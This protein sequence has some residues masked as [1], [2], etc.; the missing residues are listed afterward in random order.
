MSLSIIIP[1]HNTEQYLAECLDTVLSEINID[2]EIILVE[3]GSIDHSWE[4]CQKY[5]EKYNSVKTVRMET[6]GVSRARNYGIRLAKGD[7]ITFLDSDDCLDPSIIHMAEKLKNN[8]DMDVVLFNYCYLGSVCHEAT[9]DSEVLKH[10]DSDLLRRG[11]LQFGKY[12][13]QIKESNTLDNMSIWTCWGKLYRKKLIDDKRIRFPEGIFLSEDTAFVFQVYC[14]TDKIYASQMN[15]YYYRVTP[16]SASRTVTLKMINN[17]HRLRKWMMQYVLS[18]GLEKT[19]QE[20]ISAFLVRKFIEECLYLGISK[21]KS[22]AAKLRYTRIN[23]E[24]PYMRKALQEV[25]YRWL[26]P[27]KKNTIIYG[28]VLWFLKRKCYIALYIQK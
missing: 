25:G 12:E 17:N 11:V 24:E 13:R 23:A 9:S 16:G 10:A 2:D 19:M 20:E 26:I 18:H 8:S 22:R 21:E 15:A 7:W 27:G 5:A 4:I 6:A 3:N 28:I 1:V 14:S